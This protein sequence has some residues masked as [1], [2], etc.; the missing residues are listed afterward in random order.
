MIESKRKG[1]HLTQKGTGQDWVE[2]MNAANRGPKYGERIMNPA[3]I[4]IFR[5]RIAISRWPSLAESLETY[6]FSWKKN[7]SLMNISP[8]PCATVEKKPLRIRAAIKDSKVTA[9][10]HQ[11]AVAKATTR[12]QVRTG[13]RPK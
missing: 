3:Q 7:M 9:P 5:L 11:A 8:P 4:L 13:R 12:N 2:M 1:Q 6:A 10:A